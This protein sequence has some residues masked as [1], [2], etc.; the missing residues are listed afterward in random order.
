MGQTPVFDSKTLH[1]AL[2]TVCS[3][4]LLLYDIIKWQLLM[5]VRGSQV[6]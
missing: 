1:D 5:H 6:L 2:R 3:L 4:S